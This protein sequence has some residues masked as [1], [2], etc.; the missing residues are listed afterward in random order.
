MISWTHKQPF[1]LNAHEQDTLCYAGN[2]PYQNNPGS[3]GWMDDS[4]RH[5]QWPAVL[6]HV[7]SSGW[8]G[9]LWNRVFHVSRTCSLNLCT[10]NF[11]LCT[12]S[13]NVCIKLCSGGYLLMRV[14]LSHKNGSKTS[15]V[16]ASSWY[17][18]CFAQPQLMPSRQHYHYCMSNM[19]TTQ[20]TC[21]T[22]TLTSV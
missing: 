14:L 18:S 2:W 12:C 13:F 7:H 3:I 11:Y 21:C 22:H 5:N 4:W 8:H 15:S 10:C 6:G 1:E 16:V 20:C 9:S 19:N 17:F